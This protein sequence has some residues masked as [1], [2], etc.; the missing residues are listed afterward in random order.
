MGLTATG[1]FVCLLFVRKTFE[2]YDL[3]NLD[4]LDRKRIWIV[5]EKKKI[6][7]ISRK[8]LKQNVRSILITGEINIKN[9]RH[10][11][12]CWQ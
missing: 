6:D 11:A 10:L 2:L 8:Y 1:L 7:I 5:V 12:H 4:E 3:M 9:D